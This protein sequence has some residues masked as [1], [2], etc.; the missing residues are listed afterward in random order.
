MLIIQ[1][2]LGIV[3]AILLLNFLPQILKL[4]AWGLV[5]VIVLIL[6]WASIYLFIEYTTAFVVI[7]GTIAF[8]GYFVIRDMRDSSTS[9][10]KSYSDKERERRRELGYKD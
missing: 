1:I 7:G 10:P 8:I 9:R 5:A 6:V 2:A 4:T 3:L